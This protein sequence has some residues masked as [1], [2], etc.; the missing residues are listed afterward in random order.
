MNQFFN[1]LDNKYFYILNN[2]FVPLIIESWNKDKKN[3]YKIFK[4]ASDKE[5]S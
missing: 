5:M 1:N 3:F 2:V 4:F